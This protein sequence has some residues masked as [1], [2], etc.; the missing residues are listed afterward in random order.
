MSNPPISKKESNTT[1]AYDG[2]ESQLLRRLL[3]KSAEPIIRLLRLDRPIGIW[4]LAWPALWG[5][6]FAY[7]SNIANFTD[8]TI[9]PSPLTMVLLFIAGAF[10]TR[11]AGCVINDIVDRKID[12]QVARTKSRPIAS[13]TI[14]VPTALLIMAL[15]LIAAFIILL[16]LNNLTVGLGVFILL[17]IIIYPFMKRWTYWPQAML[18]LCFSWAALMGWTAVTNEVDWSSLLLLI[19]AFTWTMGF[20]TIYAHQDKSDDSI[21]GMKS[22]ALKFG[23]STPKWLTA[24][25]TITLVSLFI[26]GWSVGAKL[27]FFTF[28]AMACLHAIWQISTLDIDNPDN[29][30]A[31]FRANGLFGLIITV[32]IFADLGFASLLSAAP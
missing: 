4:L 15:L 17:P 5:L 7:H 9:S 10:L 29:C 13:G 24:F 8:A 19:A 16:Q 18:S 28:F 6:G 1:D 3:P 27:I 23:K 30:L 22:T 32:G 2:H 12:A 21:I 11:S 25:Y 14:S 31:R 26:V 20:D